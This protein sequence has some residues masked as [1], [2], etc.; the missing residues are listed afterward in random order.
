MDNNSTTKPRSS[1]LKELKMA[2][3]LWGNPS[4]VHKHGALAKSKLWAS[5]LAL[6]KFLGC[7]PL[8]LIFSSGASESNNHILKSLMMEDEKKELIISSVEHPS[9]L[10]VARYLEKKGIKVL[11]IPVSK[12]GE[13]DMEFFDKALSENTK[14]VSI[15]AANNETGIRYPLETLIEKTHK[16]GALFHSDMV[17]ALGKFPFHLHRLGLDF[18]SFS[19]HKFYAFKGAGLTYSKKGSPLS[20]LLHGGPQENGRRA[21]TENLLSIASFGAMAKEGEK[22]LKEYE[23]IEKLRDDMEDKILNSLESVQV[24]GKKVKRISNTSLM[25]LGVDSET[26]MIGL[27]L[28]G[29]SVSVGSACGSGKISMNSTLKAMGFSEKEARGSLR[30]SLDSRV[31]KKDLDK[32]VKALTESV[33]HLRSMK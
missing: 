16:K 18:A 15:I 23:E 22:I 17:Q 10:E 8:E 13:L 4:S 7:E 21:G 11:R 20:S 5:R 19:A 25:L 28:K 1:A 30:V 9:I 3:K 6:S 26:L 24:V 29:F 31:K 32:F 2:L 14:L 12:E 33:K 27:D